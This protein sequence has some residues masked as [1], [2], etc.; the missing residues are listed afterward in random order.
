MK[1]TEREYWQLVWEKFRNGDREAFKTIYN[2]FIDSLFVYGTK[3]TSDRELL[4]DAIQDL[5]IDVYTY[6]TKLRQPELLEFYLFKS[7]KRNLIKKLKETQKF[8][9]TKEFLE[10]FELQFTIEEEIFG[11][12]SDERLV[13]LQ[14]EINNLEPSKKELLFLKF[15]SGLSYKE[16]GKILDMKPDT[17]K[18]QVYRLLK[19]IREKIDTTFLELF[20]MCY[21]TYI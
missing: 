12:E 17:A 1:N 5:F 15:N 16:I 10:K 14:K 13:S 9:S 3:I 11:D 7:L 2:E 4:K 6:G 19:Q 18:K 20:T 21:K 8:T